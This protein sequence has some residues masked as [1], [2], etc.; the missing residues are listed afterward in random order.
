MFRQ[1]RSQGT[2]GQFAMTGFPTTG[3]A[4]AAGFTDRVWREIVVEKEFFLPRSIKAIDELL[5]IGRAE[6]GNTQRLC[7]AAREQS[8][9]VSP[10]QNAG[11]RYNWPDLIEAAPI[12][13][14]SGLDD[15]TA[16]NGGFRF[17]ESRLEHVGVHTLRAILGRNE[18]FCGTIARSPDGGLPLQL[19]CDLVSL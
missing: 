15:I 13:P 2:P 5:I 1:H 19:L 9:P 12:N 10:W 8:R 3:P 6:R 7:F 11:F 14:F 4:H 16:H 18:L 17:L